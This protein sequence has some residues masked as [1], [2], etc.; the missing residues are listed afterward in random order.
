LS[1]Y[2]DTSAFVS[3]FLKDV[4]SADVARRLVARPGLLWLTPLHR[5]EWTS[6]VAQHVFRRSI[7]AQEAQIVFDAFARNRAAGQWVEVALPPLAFDIAVEL[8]QRFT[9]LF[10]TR[11]LDTLH[12]AA[13]LELGVK[14]FWTF[15]DRQSKLA[16][17]VGLNVS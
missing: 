12:V 15:E 4:H 3:S 14:E 8:S 10:G 7:S 13:A 16:Q 5:A 2:A 11:A 17:A 9:I 1:V 6:A